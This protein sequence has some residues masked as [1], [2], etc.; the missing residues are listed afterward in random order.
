MELG[1]DTT[2]MELDDEFDFSGAGWGG[3][4]K[5][6]KD[7]DEEEDV[8]MM[9]GS[10]AVSI[11]QFLSSNPDLTSSYPPPP[12]STRNQP[13]PSSFSQSKTN[14]DHP[15]SFSEKEAIVL[16]KADPSSQTSLNPLRAMDPLQTTG[17]QS[18]ITEEELREADTIRRQLAINQRRQRGKKGFTDHRLAWE[19]ALG[20]GDSDKEEEERDDMMGELMKETEALTL[21]EK[22]MNET[23]EEMVKRKEFEKEEREFPDEVDTP[24]NMSAREKFQQYRYASFVSSP[25]RLVLSLWDAR[26]S[27]PFCT[28]GD[29]FLSLFEASLILWP[30][31]RLLSHALLRVPLHSQNAT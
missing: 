26:D 17:D 4:D 29:L 14:N 15:L 21:T 10:H 11:D 19:E 16:A 2:N 31:F 18:L 30:R 5:D 12:K 20:W 25:L 24:E 3:G 9:D 1:V 7:M 8:E 28:E 27:P 13:K 22:D 6:E 23:I